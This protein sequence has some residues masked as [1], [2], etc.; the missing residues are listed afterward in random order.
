MRPQLNAGTLGRRAKP[1]RMPELTS[2][3]WTRVDSLL[4]E[5]QVLLAVKLYL[6]VTGRGIGDAK[7][8]IG[9]RFRVAFPE[10]FREYRGVAGDD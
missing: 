5:S 8:A 10:L 6:D 7:T 3:D 2:A 9:E 4:S 1:N